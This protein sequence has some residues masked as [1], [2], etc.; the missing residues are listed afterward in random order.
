MP[1]VT[2][3]RGIADLTAEWL[4]AALSEVSDGAR[5]TEVVAVRIGNGNVADS[6]RLVPRWD[7]PTSGLDS[8]VAKVPSSNAESRAAG[9]STRTYEVEAAF[10]NELA[11]SL[12]VSR[13]HC[14]LARFV[15]EEE[16]YVILMQDL[17]PAE[18]GEQLAGCS[19]PEATAVMA[20]LAA[21]HA[22]R[23]GDPRL[24]EM[25]WLDR[26]DPARAGGT[27][28]GIRALFSGFVDRYRD[29][30][31][32]EVMDLSVRLMSDLGRYLLDRPGPWS[33]V[34]GDFR[35]D[36]LL[37]G[38][39]RVVVLDWQTVKIG[40]ALTDVGYFVGSGLLPELRRQHESALVG[41]YHEALRAG[42]V[43]IGWED[44][45][46][47][48]R[49]YACDGL[50]MGIAASMVVTR[51]ERSDEMFMAMVNRHGRQALDL[52]T[53]DLLG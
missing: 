16:A 23:W 13:P 35:V 41:R 25:D 9:F 49:R 32:P 38:G 42:G 30:V 26:P 4:N 1:V 24:L 18:P 53:L 47:G 20:E 28:E 19:P 5:V 29:R 52:A 11:D 31:E 7:R 27:V 3:P 21:L 37:F 43:E 44:C 6:V 12:L 15:P 2:V 36:N 39:A 34:H 22:P 33:V 50:V 14:Y 17:S 48:Y 45:W 40:P 46:D 8:F 10:Y 51:T